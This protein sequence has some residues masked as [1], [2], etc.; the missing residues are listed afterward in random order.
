MPNLMQNHQ[1]VHPCVAVVLSTY[2][3]A[4]YVREQLDS[5]LVQTRLPDRIV[6]SDDCST[7]GTPDIVREYAA[8]HADSP[9]SFELS[10]NDRNLGWKSNFRRMI[11]ECGADYI[12]PCDQD[13]VWDSDKIAHM[14]EIMEANP[15]FDLLACSVEPFYEDGSHK[16]LAATEQADASHGLI[17]KKGLDPDFMYV[18]RPGCSYCVR[19]SFIPKI[20][21]YWEE[22]YP[23]DATIWRYAVL[24]GGA[25]LLNERLVR[26]RRHAGNA[27][28]RKKQSREDRIAD[29]DYYIDFIGHAERYVSGNAQ[30]QTGAMQL[31]SEWSKWLVARK[32]LLETGSLAAVAACMQGRRFYSSVRG[33]AADLLLAWA[34]GARI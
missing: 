19:G 9:V 12:F 28:D 11:V 22:T 24:E 14:V 21:P 7:D 25:G 1:M 2:N 6:V 29:V 10:L 15:D 27:S 16:T 20:F 30:C 32:K 3:G 23:H 34:K 26:F 5:L 33:F 4:K 31:L 8:E 17:E 18:V 13:D